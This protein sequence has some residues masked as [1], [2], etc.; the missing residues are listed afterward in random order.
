MPGNKRMKSLESRKMKA[1]KFTK[2]NGEVDLS[3][4][5]DETLRICLQHF[6]SP[7][8]VRNVYSHFARFYDWIQRSGPEH[9]R[10]LSLSELVKYQAKKNLEATKSATN[11]AKLVDR[12][13]LLYSAIRFANSGEGWRMDYRIKLLNDVSAVFQ[14]AL[15][16][17]GG[18]PLADRSELKKLTNGVPKVAKKLDFNALR[19]IYAGSN[20]QYRAVFSVMVASGMGLSEVVQFSTQGVA[21]LEEALENPIH[22]D[23]EI[24]KVVLDGRKLNRGEFFTYI[25]GYA[26]K[27]LRAWLAKRE[28]LAKEYEKETGRRYPKTVFVSARGVPLTKTSIESYWTDVLER[29]GMKKV[30]LEE[31]KGETADE[32]RSRGSKRRTGMNVHL[33]RSVFR[34]RWEMS[35]SNEN[36]GEYFLGHTIDALGYNQIQSQTDFVIFEYLNALRWLDLDQPDPDES[37]KIS[38]KMAAEHTQTITKLQEQMASMA[39]TIANLTMTQQTPV[40]T[41]LS[42]EDIT[43]IAASA[44]PPTQAEAELFRKM[45]DMMKQ[46]GLVAAMPR[47]ETKQ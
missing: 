1:I 26:V 25:G 42:T 17:A 39:Q 21:R 11:G 38:Q 31:I 45:M 37:V 12:R 40:I 6:S 15:E 33:I 19:R 23:P 46:A 47:E 20:T 8:S 35:G 30:H 43:N 3:E 5:E 34:T 14:R 10:G 4:V 41:G 36:V 16:D 32:R 29:A 27:N 13:E 28:V 9:L 2:V 7:E 18:F 24:I 44:T 22:R